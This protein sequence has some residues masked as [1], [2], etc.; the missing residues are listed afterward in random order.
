MEHPASI[1]DMHTIFEKVEEQP[2]DKY[3]RK[4][5]ERMYPEFMNRVKEETE[6]RNILQ[7]LKP[8]WKRQ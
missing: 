7:P 6:P 5:I 8:F 4:A 2:P 3:E 1:E